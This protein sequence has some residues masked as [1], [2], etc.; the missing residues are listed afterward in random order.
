MDY[1]VS[2]SEILNCE[3]PQEVRTIGMEAWN[4]LPLLAWDYSVFS[5]HFLR[6]TGLENQSHLY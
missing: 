5:L 6:A 2:F 3:K 4:M 1:S